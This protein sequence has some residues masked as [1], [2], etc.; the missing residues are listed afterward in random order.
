MP[1]NKE[2]QTIHCMLAYIVDILI[3]SLFTFCVYVKSGQQRRFVKVRDIQ[4]FPAFME[5]FHQ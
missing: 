3:L 1:L 2:T 5:I 4:S